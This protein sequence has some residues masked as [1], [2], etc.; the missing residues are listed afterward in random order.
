MSHPINLYLTFLRQSLTESKARL[1]SANP[2]N[3]PVPTPTML[4][5]EKLCHNHHINRVLEIQIH[6]LRLVLHVV[7]STEPSPQLDIDI[8]D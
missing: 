1:G 4:R 5:L 7:L 3:P 2:R 8:F 6:V